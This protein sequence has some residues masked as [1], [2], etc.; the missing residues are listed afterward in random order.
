MPDLNR[1]LSAKEL[2]DLKAQSELDKALRELEEQHTDRAQ[3]PSKWFGRL[4]AVLVVACF[5][6][7]SGWWTA[8]VSGRFYA[9]F[10]QV[11]QTL[12]TVSIVGLAFL[13]IHGSIEAYR[14]QEARK[15]VTAEHS[16][17]NSSKDK[18]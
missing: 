9:I 14:L 13:A 7:I 4:L 15:K 8:F 17:R 16:Q 3:E 11:L 10:A 18:V 2:E 1:P 6:D 12:E 5:L